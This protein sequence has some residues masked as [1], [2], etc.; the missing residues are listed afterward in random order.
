MILEALVR[1]YEAQVAAGKIPLSGWSMAKVSFALRI[2]DAGQILDVIDLREE[3]KLGKKSVL[4]PIWLEVPEQFKRAGETIKSN[5][6][7]ENASYFLGT[8][9][10]GK[11]TRSVKCF[12]AAQKLHQ[13]ILASNNSPSAV[14]VKNF[15]TNW[16][17]AT[18]DNHPALQKYLKEIKSASN[19]IFTLDGLHSVSEDMSM[20]TAWENYRQS[21]E[22]TEGS[23]TMQCLVTGKTSLIARL[24][25]SIKGVRNAQ[26]SGA[27]LV[28]FNSPAFESYNRK[29]GQ[30]L[31]AP[32]SKYATFAYAAALNDL[33]ADS[34]H[35][36]FLGDSTVVYWAEK[37]DDAYPDCFDVISW[38]DSADISDEILDSYIQNITN[39]KPF[40]F[41]NIPLNFSTPFY[42]LGLSPNSARLSVRFFLHQ[43]FG[44]VM[45]NLARHYQDCELIQPSF[46]PK[47]LPMWQLLAATISSKSHDKF[48]SP[49]MTGAVLRAILTGADYPF[50]LFQ[51]VML[52]I[53]A[54]NDRKITYERTAVIKAY[55]TRNRKKA[56]LVALNDEI[57][58]AAYVLGRIFAVLENIQESAN[59]GLNAT[60]KDK[61][62]NAACATPARIFPILQKLSVHHLRKLGV[63]SKIFFD[64]QLTH[65]MEKLS[66]E[67]KLPAL[68]SLEEQGMFIL[69]YYHQTQERYKKKEEKLNGELD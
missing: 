61:Y 8:D 64:K 63:G 51:N 69:G 54:E 12:E 45:Q 57:S 14:A 42:I 58:D 9:N 38:R 10:K 65:L 27:S 24:H 5:F 50:S 13:E 19:L 35:V 1:R 30:G 47:Y 3:K 4:V 66:A 41:E 60:I 23:L 21:Q 16:T 43:T 56:N 68:L 48:S 33:L 25:P 49:L 29:D 28:S 32:V 53:K 20:K 2:N 7:C 26:S 44:E 31:N 18:A 22:D 59:P 37:S 62:F 46:K 6:L 40:D 55:L 11:P 17:P 34:K 15:F 67:A 52:R 36:K 39:A